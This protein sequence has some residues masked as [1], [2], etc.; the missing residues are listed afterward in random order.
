MR[1]GRRRQ[2][3]RG[4]QRRERR[5]R[6]PAN[7]RGGAGKAGTSAPGRLRRAYAARH[8]SERLPLPIRIAAMPTTSAS[9]P[10]A[11]ATI[12]SVDVPPPPSDDLA[13]IT[14]AG[15]SDDSGPDQLTTEPS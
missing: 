2:R 13:S 5:D 14:G 6:P 11:I 12:A 10:T 3:Q 9:P 4:D 15:A 7:P 8:A 1:P